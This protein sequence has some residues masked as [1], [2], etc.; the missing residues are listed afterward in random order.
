MPRAPTTLLM[1]LLLGGAAAQAQVQPLPERRALPDLPKVGRVTQVDLH[2]EVDAS[3]SAYARR[4]LDQHREGEIVLLDINTLGGRLDAALALRDAILS[5]KVTTVCWVHPRAISAGALIALACDVLVVAPGASMGAATPVQLTSVGMKPV[6]DKVTSYMRS[7]MANTA[8]MQSRPTLIAEAMVDADVE[9]PGLSEKGKLLTMDE[10]QA[11]EHGV[12]DVFA[13]E[14]P[15]LWTALDRDAPRIEKAHPTAAESVARLLSLPAVAMVL[16]VVGLLGIAIELFHPTNGQAL[17]VGLAAL[18]LFLFGHYLVALSGWWELVIITAGVGLL[19]VEWWLPGNTVFGVVGLKLL[20]FGLALALVDLQHLP[21]SM[22]WTSGLLTRALASV[23]GALIL[24]VGG[25]ALL[26]RYAP[27]THAG[28]G[29]VL[30]AVLPA[31]DS[32][33]AGVPL[34]AMVGE[35]GFALTDLRPVGKVEIMGRTVEA[36]AERGWAAAG[37]RVRAVGADGGRLVVREDPGK[38]AAVKEG[39]A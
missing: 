17:M 25:V 36:R 16:M 13:S 19:L 22:A 2:G 34:T 21:L 14:L 37:T 18:A 32:Q 3:L 35:S 15:A 39:A 29:L 10:H 20:L 6:D 30:Q 26:V 8:R 7:E 11:L 5:A 4:V 24:A 38:R 28:R 27:A 31:G 12:A 33:V 1:L 23:F 9:I